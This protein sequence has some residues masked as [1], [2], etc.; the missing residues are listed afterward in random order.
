MRLQPCAAAPS[1][2]I[3][4]RR[5]LPQDGS[6]TSTAKRTTLARTITARSLCADVTCSQS[7]R[8]GFS[9]H[10]G[11]TNRLLAV[12]IASEAQRVVLDPLRSAL[13]KIVTNLNLGLERSNKGWPTARSRYGLR[14]FVCSRVGAWSDATPSADPGL[15][16]DASGQHCCTGR[17]SLQ[18]E[19]LATVARPDLAIMPTCSR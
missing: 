17:C 9:V 5:S 19:L 16:T 1:T 15:T 6:S 4:A 2:D 7:I 13:R 10:T 14:Q 8:I 11:I 3:G 12:Q 18:S